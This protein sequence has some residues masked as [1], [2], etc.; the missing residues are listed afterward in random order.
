MAPKTA[1]KKN[2]WLVAKEVL[3][4]VHVAY[5]FKKLADDANKRHTRNYYWAF[6]S[7]VLIAI[8]EN[9]AKSVAFH[10]KAVGLYSIDGEPYVFSYSL[11]V[12]L[13]CF[14]VKLSLAPVHKCLHA[15]EKKH[16]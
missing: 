4:E 5:V 11:C 13:C 3:Q 16:P 1:A 9:L 7:V 14:I 8:M 6:M 2:H 15:H 10:T 12:T